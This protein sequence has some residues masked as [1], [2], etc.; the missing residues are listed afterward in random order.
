M[1]VIG[2]VELVVFDFDGVFTD[3]AVWV[4]EDGVEL[5]RCDRSDGLGI[6]RLH[7]A[8]VPVLVLSTERNPVVAARCAK[9]H[10]PV[11]HGVADKGAW[12]RQHLS[13]SAIDPGKVVYV[14]NDINDA[15]CLRLAGVPVVVADAHPSVKSLARFV[16]THT[17]GH[18]AVREL[19]DALVDG[20]PLLP[21]PAPR[22]PDGHR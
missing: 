3:N 19:C 16:L 11:H 15:D 9:L 6:A 13:D 7:E 2:S 22:S 20:T 18:G 14:G 17:G 1:T 10:I 21:N 8:G 5:V 12:L 4:R